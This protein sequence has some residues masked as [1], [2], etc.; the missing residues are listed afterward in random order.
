MIQN[1]NFVLFSRAKN[2][3]SDLNLKNHRLLLIEIFKISKLN[4][5]SSLDKYGWAIIPIFHEKTYINSGVFFLP[6]FKE[7]I[8]DK[9]T[10]KIIAFK[11][12][13]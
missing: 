13:F 7:S 10:K 1:D 3:Y 4:S 8:S 11:C 6:I 2:I 9:L 12:N 5:I